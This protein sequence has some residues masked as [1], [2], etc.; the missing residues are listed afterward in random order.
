MLWLKALHLIAM[1]TWFAGLFYLPR[2]FVYHTQVSDTDGNQ[3]FQIMERKLFAIMT[4]GALLTIVF[5]IWLIAGYGM[6]WFRHQHWL[7]AKLVFVIA[8]IAFHAWCGVIVRR[9]AAGRNTRPERFYRL[10]NEIPVIPLV[11][12]IFLAVLRPF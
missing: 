9:F 4:L 5:G 1:V 12:I 3:R 8:L 11:G 7:H 2:L 6:E 10:I